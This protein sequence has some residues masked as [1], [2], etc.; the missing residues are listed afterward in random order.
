[1][2]DDALL[3]RLIERAEYNVHCKPATLCVEIRRVGWRNAA[4]V[5]NHLENV[6]SA[7]AITEG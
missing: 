7:G 4:G 2:S 1:M 6:P 5:L 3:A